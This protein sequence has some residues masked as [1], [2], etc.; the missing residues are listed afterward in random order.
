MNDATAKRFVTFEGIDGAGKTTQMLL[1]AEW[2]RQRNVDFRL[3]REPGGSSIG[4]EIRKLLLSNEGLDRRLLPV[5]EVMLLMA[6]RMQ[7]LAEVVVP[8]IEAGR[9]VISDRFFDSTLAY[10]GAG[11]RMDLRWLKSFF[12]AEGLAPDLTVYFKISPLKALERIRR[13]A[14]DARPGDRFDEETLEFFKRVAAEYDSLCDAYPSRYRTLDASLS[15]ETVQENLRELIL[16]ELF[17][18][19]S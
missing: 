18:Q 10:Q 1:L 12:A 4:E 3:T 7:H 11:R 5:S 9:L 14:K 6:D 19:R 17:P 15:P 2:M 16:R 13:R 8:A